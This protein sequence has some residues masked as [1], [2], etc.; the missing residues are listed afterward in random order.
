MFPI[1]CK[2]QYMQYIQ[3]VFSIYLSETGL[4]LQLKNINM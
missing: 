3:V 4:K 2:V 1:I